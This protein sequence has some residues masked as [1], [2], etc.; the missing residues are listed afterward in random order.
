MFSSCFKDIYSIHQYI[1]FLQSI[2]KYGPQLSSLIFI[3]KQW[4]TT[5]DYLV[6]VGITVQSTKLLL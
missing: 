4:G 2:S 5:K 6:L 3:S 1:W